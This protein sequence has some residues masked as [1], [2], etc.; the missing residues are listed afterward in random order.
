MSNTRTWVA[1]AIAL[2]LV[3]VVGG[4][5][6]GISPILDQVSAAN[7]QKTTIQTS[8]AVSQSQLASLKVQ[9][10]AIG[11]LK[12][13]LT[14]LRG[15]VPEL[16]GASSFFDELTALSAQYGVTVTSLSLANATIYVDPTAAA[17]GTTAPPD[18][19]TATSPTPT[20]STPGLVLVPVDLSISG[21]FNNV[22]DFIGAAQTGTR[23]FFISSASISGDPSGTA[24]ASLSGDVFSLQG[25]SDPVKKAKVAP[26]P[27]ATATPTPTMTATPT[28]TPTPTATTSKAGSKTGT[29]APPPAAPTT[30]ETPSPT[31]TP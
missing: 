4:Y 16:E 11:K 2:A 29:T 17:A 31:P 8:N 22:R 6:V 23:L 1:G 3:I 20:V 21:P 26:V 28:P 7:S 10:A 24:S 12:S 30:A 14:E 9:F 18:A 19:S 27:T 5:L 13:K 25:T 15:S